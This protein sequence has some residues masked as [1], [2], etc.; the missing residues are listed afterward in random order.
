MIQASCLL[1]RPPC[2]ISR[3]TRWRDIEA[4]V[5]AETG[6]YVYSVTQGSVARLT[7]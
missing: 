5:S 4:V 2:W 6:P 7:P 3:C 1:S